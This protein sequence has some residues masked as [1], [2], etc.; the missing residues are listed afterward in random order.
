[1]AVNYIQALRL[2][3]SLA[4]GLWQTPGSDS[5]GFNSSTLAM[6]G[7][8]GVTKGHKRFSGPGA[9]SR[10]PLPALVPF[11][12]ANLKSTGNVGGPGCVGEGRG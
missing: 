6:F 9:P 12:S 2:P 4:L 5:S 8:V 7:R 1:M 11:G 3:C 10:C